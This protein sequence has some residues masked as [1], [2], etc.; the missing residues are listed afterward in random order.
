MSFVK[1][2]E[3]WLW[4]TDACFLLYDDVIMYLVLHHWSYDSAFFMLNAFRVMRAKSLLRIHKTCCFPYMD[5]DDVLFYLML[6][7][8]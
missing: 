5:P 3:M 1:V 7:L 6:S 8:S 4:S 2:V